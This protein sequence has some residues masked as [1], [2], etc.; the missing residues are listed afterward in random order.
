MTGRTLPVYR[1]HSRNT[2]Y[3]IRMHM[4]TYRITAE[5]WKREGQKKKAIKTK[6][7]EKRTKTKTKTKKRLT[8]ELFIRRSLICGQDSY[9]R[10]TYTVLV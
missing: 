9:L 1:H 4:T 8:T 10:R 7:E 6:G 3:S 5:E 2:R